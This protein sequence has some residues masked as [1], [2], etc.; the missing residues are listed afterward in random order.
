[1]ERPTKI[2]AT[3]I[4]NADLAEELRGAARMLEDFADLSVDEDPDDEVITADGRY[5]ISEDS[6]LLL[7][8]PRSSGFHL[9]ADEVS[10]FA[11]EG[12]AGR[13]DGSSLRAKHNS[14]LLLEPVSSSA[15]ALS[16]QELG[17]L[18]DHFDIGGDDDPDCQG[19]TILFGPTP[20]ALAVVK[21]DAYDKYHPPYEDDQAVLCITHDKYIEDSRIAEIADAYLFELTT[22]CG[23][24]FRRSTRPDDVYDDVEEPEDLL[25]RAERM[26]PLLAGPGIP[27]LLGLFNQAASASEPSY[28]ILGFAKVVEYVASTVARMESFEQLRVKLAAPAA[29]RP[30]ARF[31]DDLKRTV[32][33]QQDWKKDKIA[34]ELAV[35]RCCDADELQRYAVPFSQKLRGLNPTSSAKDRDQALK[36]FASQ[37]SSTRNALSHAKPNY[38]ASGDEC[39]PEQYESFARLAWSAAEMAIRWYAQSDPS[40][41]Y[42]PGAWPSGGQP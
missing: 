17:P 20:I 21:H 30:D 31:L 3:S 38:R 12:L 9:R 1:M 24:T 37:L 27:Q 7:L 18:Q 32:E 34:M 15:F 10:L 23:I 26:R 6:R 19:A 25:K 29:L 11:E 8:L 41:R 14:Y 22:S 2:E 40:M 4:P 42:L 33:G 5:E 39:P 28:Q 36:E 13:W 35:V 16:A